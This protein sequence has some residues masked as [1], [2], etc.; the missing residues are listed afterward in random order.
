MTI[1]LKAIKGTQVEQPFVS[2]GQ[3]KTNSSKKKNPKKLKT[4]TVKI[5]RKVVQNKNKVAIRQ[6]KFKYSSRF[7]KFA[8]S[9]KTNVTLTEG[10]NGYTKRKMVSRI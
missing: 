6:K 5:N 4:K 9:P 7:I 2:Q 3:Q 10:T 8:R 1:V